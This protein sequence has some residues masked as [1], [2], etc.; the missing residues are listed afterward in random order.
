LE[1]ELL[2]SFSFIRLKRIKQ[3]SFAQSVYPSA[4]HTRYEHSIGARHICEKICDKVIEK[5]SNN[6]R[7]DFNNCEVKLVLLSSLLHDIGHPAF[8]HSI[9]S[10]LSGLDSNLKCLKDHEEA[11]FKI[12]TDE[13]TGINKILKEKGKLSKSE[14]NLVANIAVGNSSSLK[15][16]KK[17]LTDIIA[18]DFGCDRIDYLKRDAY[19][20]GSSYGLI[21]VPDLIDNIAIAT[22]PDGLKRIGIKLDQ[23]RAG[24]E[25]VAFLQLSRTFHF[26]RIVHQYEIREANASLSR[27]IKEYIDLIEWNEKENFINDLFLKFDDCSLLLELI[28]KKGYKYSSIRKQ[29]KKILIEDYSYKRT[30]YQ[31]IRRLDDFSPHLRYY[32]FLI[33]THKRALFEKK[34][35]DELKMKFKLANVIVDLNLNGKR[36]IPSD[37]FVSVG[38]NEYMPNGTKE[39]RS[40]LVFDKVPILFDLSSILARTGTFSVYTSRDIKSIDFALIQNLAKDLVRKIREEQD[41]VSTDFLLVYLHHRSKIYAKLGE[42]ALSLFQE[43]IPGISKLMYELMLITKNYPI[44]FSCWKN[45]KKDLDFEMLSKDGKRPF[46]FNKG[47]LKDIFILMG[48]DFLEIKRTPIGFDRYGQ[49]YSETW[50][51]DSKIHYMIYRWDFA[52]SPSSVSY[53]KKELYPTKYDYYKNLIETVLEKRK[54]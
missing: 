18:G 51:F 28:K 27:L 47:V 38:N 41:I 23:T 9:E 42:Y 53:I 14:I 54:Y 5:G 21:E 30:K 3:L 13:N 4:N 34:V 20:T 6:Q 45:R 1:C 40:V 52:L 35:E 17:F 16:E 26:S 37:L 49:K 44:K 43:G 32:L 7:Y 48:M 46:Y 10:L 19:Y 25:A 36:G 8:S 12:I 11:T 31:I 50:D 15:K 29:A 22:F 24:V 33:F 39:V 2:K